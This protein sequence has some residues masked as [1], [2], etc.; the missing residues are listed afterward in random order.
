VLHIYI[1][2]I[3]RLRVKA[4]KDECYGSKDKIPIQE[5]LVEVNLQA[6]MD[7]TASRIIMVKKM[8]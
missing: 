6:L 7:K 4:A 8:P 5:S 1:Y 3:S 2:D